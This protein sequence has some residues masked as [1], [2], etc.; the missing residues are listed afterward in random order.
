MGS[1]KKNREKII[2]FWDSGPLHCSLV[3]VVLSSLNCF[4]FRAERKENSSKWDCPRRILDEAP[5]PIPAPCKMLPFFSVDFI[6]P[7][8]LIAQQGIFS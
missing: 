8:E 5:A 7:W 6:V 4:T 3:L 2:D 1:K